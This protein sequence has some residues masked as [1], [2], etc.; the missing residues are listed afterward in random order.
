MATKKSKLPSLAELRS[1][2]KQ[3][4]GKD[5]TI[6]EYPLQLYVSLTAPVEPVSVSHSDRATMRRMLKAALEVLPPIPDGG[7]PWWQD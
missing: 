6:V 1:L 3:T 4:C 2:A 5:A 7:K